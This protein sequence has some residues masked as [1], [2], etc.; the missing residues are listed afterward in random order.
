MRLP[1]FFRKHFISTLGVITL[2]LI[3]GC[4]K[5]EP[6]SDPLEAV[7]VRFAG[8][9]GQSKSWKIIEAETYKYESGDLLRIELDE[10][11]LNNI[12]VF[13]NNDAKEGVY[14]QLNDVSTC[15]GNDLSILE[16]GKW[17]VYNKSETEEL[18][19][20]VSLD[21][22]LQ[23]QPTSSLFYLFSSF[24]TKEQ[25]TVLRLEDDFLLLKI[26]SEFYAGSTDIV[27]F[28]SYYTF[29]EFGS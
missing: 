4:S 7:R 29:I 10:C 27:S 1:I 22:S 2:L 12:F 3:S 9:K 21:Y 5:N 11:N 16:R 25:A 13:E 23:P 18:I 6:L 19:V 8:E 14:T 15:G 20:K 24:G 28:T 17:S 26:E